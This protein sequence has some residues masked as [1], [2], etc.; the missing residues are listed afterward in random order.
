[1]SNKE[2][3]RKQRRRGRGRQDAGVP[4]P[5]LDVGD[6]NAH[7]IPVRVPS[8]ASRKWTA[9]EITLPASQWDHRPHNPQTQAHSKRR[10]MKTRR[11]THLI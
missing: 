5:P 1:M 11:T 7:A 6:E 8:Q 2:G 9:F 4:Q 3:H 10:L